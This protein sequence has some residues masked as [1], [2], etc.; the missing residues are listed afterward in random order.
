[1]LLYRMFCVYYINVIFF[2]QPSTTK[3]LYM[4]RNFAMIQKI[5]DHL[6]AHV[7]MSYD[8]STLFYQRIK[9]IK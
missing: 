1:M 4:M 8:N 6:S 5:M 9:K 2:C 3:N 7:N